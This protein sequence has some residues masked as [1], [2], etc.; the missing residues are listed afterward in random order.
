[1]WIFDTK[2]E[3]LTQN[4]GFLDLKM[5]IFHPK[6]GAVFGVESEEFRRGIWGFFELKNRDFGAGK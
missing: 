2:L 6:S 4:R 3:V 1:M 5:R